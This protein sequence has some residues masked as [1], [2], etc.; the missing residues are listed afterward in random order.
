MKVLYLTKLVHVSPSIFSDAVERG[1]PQQDF[2]KVGRDLRVSVEGQIVFNHAA[3]RLAPVHDGLGVAY[4][5]EDL[6]CNTVV[7]KPAEDAP[8]TCVRF[9][10][11][12]QQ[13]EL[14]PRRV[15]PGDRAR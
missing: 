5:P 2:E 10:E 7:R 14:P 9:A 11:I 4:L 6:V 3:L 15:Q 13:A 12:I 8:L 1:V